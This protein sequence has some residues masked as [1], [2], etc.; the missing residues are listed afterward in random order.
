MTTWASRLPFSFDPLIAE[1]KQR[2]RRRRLLVVTIVLLLVGSA[3]GAGLTLGGPAPPPGLAFS[4]TPAQTKLSPLGNLATRRADCGNRYSTCHSSDG[5][6]S[7]VFINRSPGP[8]YY[9]YANGRV[10]TNANHKVGC[11]LIVT[12]LTTGRRKDVH[13][14]RVPA[15]ENALF[16]GQTYFAEDPNRTPGLGRM[17]GV[18]PPSSQV[19]T[20]A[21]FTTYIVSP[22]E[23][24]IAGEAGALDA[25]GSRLIAVYSPTSHACRVVARATSPNQYVSVETSGWE[26]GPT[27]PPGLFTFKDPVAWHNVVQGDRTI[28]VATGPGPGFTQDSRSLIVAEWQYRTK[29]GSQSGSGVIHRRLVKF[30]LSSL[31]TPCPE[32][33][34]Q[35]N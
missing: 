24:W 10:S 26:F 6:W 5:R 1:A 11:T 33:V 12:N 35:P 23:S 29:E 7:I 34:A 17:V 14:S 20:L 22:D 31:H 30:D 8:V 15:C 27:R 4:P 18:E 3:L 21:N 16:I 19:K 9:S 13:L 2:M 32:S 28:Q 25:G